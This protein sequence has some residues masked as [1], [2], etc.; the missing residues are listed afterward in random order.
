MTASALVFIDRLGRHGPLIIGALLMA[1]WMYANAG[2]MAGYVFQSPAW[3]RRQRAQGELADYRRASPRRHRV[4]LSLRRVLRADCFVPPAFVNIQW[5]AY[6]IFGVFCTVMAIHIFFLFPKTSGETLE[7]VEEI[8]M[9][10]TSAWK[11]GVEFNKILVAEHG[12]VSD[13][14]QRSGTRMSCQKR[15]RLRFPKYNR[16]LRSFHGNSTLPQWETGPFL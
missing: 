13:K 4:H 9:T 5:K 3:R 2:L 6:V 16:S 7:V 14:R 8:F 10:G 1:T 11:T 12:D 15:T